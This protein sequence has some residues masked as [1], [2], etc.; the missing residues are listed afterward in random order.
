MF[1]MENVIYLFQYTLIHIKQGF[2]NLSLEVHSAA[3][4]SSD[5]DQTVIF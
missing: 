2:S 5:P 3:E 4:F 1:F